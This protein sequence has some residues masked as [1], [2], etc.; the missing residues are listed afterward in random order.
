MTRK[1]KSSL[2]ASA[3]K[4]IDE[5]QASVA[6]SSRILPENIPRSDE[7]GPDDPEVE[8]VQDPR[9]PLS[10]LLFKTETDRKPITEENAERLDIIL[11]RIIGTPFKILVL[12][13]FIGG[14]QGVNFWLNQLGFLIQYP[15]YQC[16]FTAGLKEEDKEGLCTEEN[17][18][19]GDQ[20]IMSWKIDNNNENT[21]QNWHQKLDL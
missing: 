8:E 21:L 14:I 13:I 2:R 20:R 4:S 9:Q 7:V 1:K 16:V 5:S 19:A 11:E 17:I 6:Q 3:G 18:C 15:H 10:S 12:L